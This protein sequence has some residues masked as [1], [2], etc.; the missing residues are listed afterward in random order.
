MARPT[1]AGEVF[2]LGRMRWRPGDA[3]E[4]RALL[5]A[6]QSAGKGRHDDILRAA[7]IGG[8]AQGQARADQVEDT[9]TAA[10]LDEMLTDF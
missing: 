1:A 8:M 9:E 2:Y 6:I 4:L 5:A 7:L 3:P 10:A